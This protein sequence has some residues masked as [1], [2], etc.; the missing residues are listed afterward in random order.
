M[1]TYVSRSYHTHLPTEYLL[2]YTRLRGL[3]EKGKSRA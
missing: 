2:A 1:T 3:D